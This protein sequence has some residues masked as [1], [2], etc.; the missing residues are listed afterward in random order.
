M[1]FILVNGNEMYEISFT[2]IPKQFC[3]IVPVFE[4]LNGPSYSDF[5]EETCN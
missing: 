3:P 1:R 4:F 5:G 2:L